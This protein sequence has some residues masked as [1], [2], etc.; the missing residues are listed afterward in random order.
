MFFGS[1]YFEEKHAEWISNYITKHSKIKMNEYEVSGRLLVLWNTTQ[2]LMQIYVNQEDLAIFSGFPRSIFRYSESFARTSGV[3]KLALV[4]RGLLIPV[5]G[6]EDFYEIA[7][8]AKRIQA[9]IDKKKAGKEAAMRRWEKNKTMGNPMGVLQQTQ[10][11]D[12]DNDNVSISTAVAKAPA[13]PR[14]KKPKEKSKGSLLFDEYRE[15]YLT[16][17]D[18]CPP[19]GPAEYTQLNRL[20]TKVGFEMAKDLLGFYVVDYKSDY[21]QRAKHPIGLFTHN[22]NDI[23]LKFKEMYP[24]AHYER[25]KDGTVA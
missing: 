24:N 18:H 16:K 1:E 8:N 5:S 20:I 7:G 14:T 2:K 21:C 10:C 9:I 11:N 3:W 4:E 15:V 25:Q 22:F 23:F 6:R 17:Y 12:N 13:K 19:A